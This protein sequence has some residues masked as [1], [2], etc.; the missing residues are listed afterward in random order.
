MPNPSPAQESPDAL[1]QRQEAHDTG[2]QSLQELVRALRTLAS[3]TEAIPVREDLRMLIA[4][5]DSL[6]FRF[7]RLR[8]R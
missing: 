4:S 1:K 3:T 2:V 6:T 5:A 7:Q 8:P